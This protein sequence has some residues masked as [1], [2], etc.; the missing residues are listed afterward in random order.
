MSP[1]L[2]TTDAK[3]C[4]RNLFSINGKRRKHCLR[5]TDGLNAMDSV[6]AGQQGVRVVEAVL[7]VLWDEIDQQVHLLLAHRLD[8]EAFVI[9][10]EEDA[11]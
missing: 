6:E 9:R 3:W 11:A 10:N 5:S 8:H 7:V 2:Q 1:H 4:Q